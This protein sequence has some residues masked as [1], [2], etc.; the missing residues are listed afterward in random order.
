METRLPK[1]CVEVLRSGRWFSSLPAGLQEALLSAAVT[2]KLA[3]GE[4]LFARGADFDGLYAV[5]QGA[6]RVAGTIDSGK[7]ILLMLMEPPLW[8]GEISL[9]DGQ[10]RT[11]D[12]VAEEETLLAHVPREAIEAILAAE[13]IYWR[14]VGVLVAAKLRVALGVIEDTASLPIAIRLAR[15]LVMAAERYGDWHGRSSKV[16]DLKQDQLATMLS[17]SRQT[18]NQLLKDLEARGLVRI[19]YGNVEILDLDGLRRAAKP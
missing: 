13:P 6:I 10:P 18:V 8:F 2:K 11:H 3:K 5:V 19:A 7:E 16:L 14:H 17:T 4:W 1:R 15:R 9:L 12:A